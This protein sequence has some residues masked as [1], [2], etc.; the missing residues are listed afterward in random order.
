MKSIKDDFDTEVVKYLAESGYVR[1]R[2]LIEDLKKKHKKERGYSLKS[3]NRKLDNLINQNKIRSLKY[4]D[5]ENL[6]IEDN[7][8]RASYLTL[9]DLPKIQEHL[10][11]VLEGLGSEDSIKQKMALKEIVRYE[12]T[13]ILNP[14]QLELVVTQFEKVIERENIDNE[15]VD[16]LIILLKNYIL[17]KKIEPA[18]K[19]KTVCLLT[20]LLKKYPVPITRYKNLRTY[21]LYLLGYYGHEAVIE[22]FMDDARTLQ[23]L[24]SLEENNVYNTKD[25]AKLIEEHREELFVLEEDLAIE[26]KTEAAQFVSNV[27]TTAMI[28]LGLH[29][30]P[31]SQENQEIDF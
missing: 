18:N 26:G 14:K 25:I 22:R 31:Y 15:L 3:I 8:K 9:T 23:D 21:I 27:R 13:Y 19:T 16:K 5:F 7:D 17:E 20:N 24:H 28:I 29:E 4:S 30:N 12:Q 1:R 2:Q 6:G 11:K 10:D